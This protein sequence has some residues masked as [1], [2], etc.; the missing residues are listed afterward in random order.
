[1]SH[2][3]PARLTAAIPMMSPKDAEFAN[4]LLE[5]ARTR[6]GLTERQAYWADVL[7][8]RT[9]EPQPEQTVINVG[10]I[11]ELLT[12]A[13]GKLKHPKV[14]LSTEDGQRVVLGIAGD[15][16]KYTGSVMVTDGGPFGANTYYGRI[17]PDGI[18]T[19]SR[20]MTPAVLSL[21]QAFAADP[22]GIGAKIGKMSGACC[23]CS[24]QLDTRESLAVGYGPTCATKYGLPWG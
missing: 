19:P 12:R 23:F 14:R 20:S 16:S 24:R 9:M 3:L 17:S 18:L 8:R 2:D 6:H 1:M 7:I 5:S 10:G 11:I 4:S 21:L 22:A 13:S 15:R